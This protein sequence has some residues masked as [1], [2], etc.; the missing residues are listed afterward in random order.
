LV[1]EVVAGSAVTLGLRFPVGR[2]ARLRVALA[3]CE[4]LGL[5]PE[6]AFGSEDL[7]PW[8]YDRVQAFLV[9]QLPWRRP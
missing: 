5:P 2:R 9:E 1:V 3:L 6:C 4:D 7:E 8:R